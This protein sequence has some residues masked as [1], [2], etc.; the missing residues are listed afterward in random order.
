ML[1]IVIIAAVIAFTPE[2]NSQ[3]KLRS[4]TCKAQ[5]KVPYLVQALSK[6]LVAK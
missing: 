3:T 5:S 4:K 2:P 1:Y 6:I